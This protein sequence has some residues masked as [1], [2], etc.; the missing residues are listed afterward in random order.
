[1]IIYGETLER[2]LCLGFQAHSYGCVA[3]YQAAASLG[4]GPVQTH[5]SPVA[6]SL[7]RT[8]SVRLTQ[9]LKS[10]LRDV[11]NLLSSF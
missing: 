3:E 9:I 6:T 8:P 1:M 10:N 5:C 2:R 4:G 11:P 7:C